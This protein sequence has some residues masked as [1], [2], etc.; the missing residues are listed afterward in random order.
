M[1]NKTTLAAFIAAIMLAVPAVA[2]EEKRGFYI[3]PEIG[4]VKL[5]DYCSEAFSA[6]LTSCEDSELGFGLSGGYWLNEFFAIE[7]GGR[8]ASGFDLSDGSARAEI[9]VQTFNLGARGK[10]PVGQHFFITGKTGIHFWDLKASGPGGS[11]SDDGTDP[12]YGL[13][14]GFNFNE[15]I[16]ALAEYTRYKFDDSDA[17]VISGNLV[18]NF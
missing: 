9:D 14:I 15:R 13:G 3:A 5:K 16:G 17:D 11:L 2:E 1:K 12:Y 7:G 4:Q 10:F 6:G 8:L 18:F